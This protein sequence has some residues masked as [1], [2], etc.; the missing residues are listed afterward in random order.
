MN[1]EL[2]AV[3]DLLLELQEAEKI[4]VAAEDRGTYSITYDFGGVY[5]ILCC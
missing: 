2:E 1:T 4:D 3:E 5:S